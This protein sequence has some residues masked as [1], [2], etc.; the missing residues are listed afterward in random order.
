M[1]DIRLPFDSLHSSTETGIKLV[2]KLGNDVTA[3]MLEK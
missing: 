2:D 3:Q 1:S